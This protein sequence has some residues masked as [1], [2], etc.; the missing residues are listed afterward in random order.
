MIDFIS[1]LLPEGWK[2]EKAFDDREIYFI[3]C[4]GHGAVT[5][6]MKKRCAALGYYSYSSETVASAKGKNWKK[7]IIN[8]AVNMLIEVMGQQKE[9]E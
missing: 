5:V 4:V 3:E 1:G 6:D 9:C 7:N 8:H 2:V